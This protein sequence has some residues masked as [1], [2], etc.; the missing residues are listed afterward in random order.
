MS[1][2]RS[3]PPYHAQATLS[4]A[5]EGEAD[6]RPQQAFL[7]LTSRSSGLAAYFAAV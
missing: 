3:P 6:F 7:R 4:V 1:R 5:L 2:R